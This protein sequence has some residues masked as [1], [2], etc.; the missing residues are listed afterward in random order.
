[1]VS[2]CGIAV[3]DNSLRRFVAFVMWREILHVMLA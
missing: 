3:L 1:M 2:V